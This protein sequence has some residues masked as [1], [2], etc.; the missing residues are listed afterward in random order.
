MRSYKLFM[1][2]HVSCSVC[3]MIA[4]L[5]TAV[6]AKGKAMKLPEGY[7]AEAREHIGGL[8]YNKS[9]T[10]NWFERNSFPFCKHDGIMGYIHVDRRFKEGLDRSW[11]SYTYDLHDARRIWMYPEKPCRINTYGNSFTSCEQVNDGET[12]QEFLGA[13]LGEPV[14][15]YGAGGY[16]VYQSYLRMK[17]EE[18]VTPAKYIIINIFDDDHKRNFIS[19]QRIWWGSHPKSYHPTLPYVEA[20]PETG[21]FEEFANPCPTRESLAKLTDLEW[22]LDRFKDD[23]ITKI[24]MA[25]RIGRKTAL[26]GSLD[27][28][29][30]VALAQENIKKAAEG[31]VR[32]GM[33]ARLR[34]AGISQVISQLAADHGMPATIESRQQLV[35]VADQVFMKAALYATTRI[36]ELAEEYAAAND[37]KILYVLSYSS[38]RVI[39][40][41]K[42]GTRFDQSVVDYLDRK[43]LPYVDSLEAHVADYTM[44]NLTPEEYCKRYYIGHYGPS[45]NFFHAFSIK[46]KLVEMLDPKPVSYRETD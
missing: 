4:V 20:N 16:S 37:R 32:E 26:E 45:G 24:A 19:W 2:S 17:K 27:W 35:Q 8:L 3:I 11:V 39:E 14:R 30:D 43:G 25:H 22:S 38:P 7:I 46:D 1:L 41:L 44:F 10:D 13:H 12:W 40:R 31:P 18:P 33:E 5:T 15:N 28:P 36:I 23:F 34:E 29:T 42:E 21:Y 6:T 9:D